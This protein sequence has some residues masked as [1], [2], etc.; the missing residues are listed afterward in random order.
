MIVGA[1]YRE[2][3]SNRQQTRGLRRTAKVGRDVRT[4]N[5]AGQQRNGGIID[6][7]L[8]SEDFKAT[9][10]IAVR[11][12]RTWCIERLGVLLSCDD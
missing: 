8:F 10:A 7:E 3:I 6:P 11:V 12:V 2:S 5:D 1:D 4:M 9:L